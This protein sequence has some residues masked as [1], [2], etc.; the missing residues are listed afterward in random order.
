MT[1]KAI[2]TTRVDKQGYRLLRHVVPD[3]YEITIMPDL[4][5]FRFSGEETIF[6]R[7]LQPC[8]QIALN[9]KDLT[10]RS[11]CVEDEHGTRLEGSV[12]LDSETEMATIAFAGTLG[13][14]AWKLHL[15]FRGIHNDKLKGFYRA[16]WKDARGR[17]RWAAV[18]QFESTDARRAFPCFDEPEFKAV[19]SVKLVVDKN[20]TALSNGKVVKETLVAA[21]AGRRGNRKRTQVKK[22]VEFA[23][24]IKMSTYL[25]AFV[26]GDFVGSKPV[27]VDGI[28]TRVFTLPGKEHLTDFALEQACRATAFLNRETGMRF[29]G[30]HIYHVAIPN[31]ASGAMENWCLVTYRETALLCDLKTATHAEKKRVA[32]VV[33]HE[34]AHNIHFG[35]TVTMKWWNGLWLNESFATFQENWGVSVEY[36]QWNIWEEF[37]PSRA[38]A[39]RLDSLNTTHPIECVVNRPEDADELFD[40]ISYEKGCSIL[41]QIQ[42]FIGPEIFRQGVAAYIRKHAFGNTET[43]DLWDSLEEAC[44]A[45]GLNIPVRRIMDGWVF[46]PGHPVVT[47]TPAGDGFIDL[48]QQPFKF[49][50][51]GG[52]SQTWPVPVTVRVKKVNGEIETR[53]FLFEGK[54]HREFVGNYQWVVVNAGGSGFYR[55]RYE[56]SLLGKLTANVGENLSII[57]RFNLVNDTWSCVRAG[58]VSA[59]EYLEMLKLFAGETDPNV[60]SIITGSLVALNDLLPDAKKPALQ[61]LVRNLVAPAV[62]RLGWMAREGESVQ[63]SQ[64]R[65]MLIGVLGTIGGDTAVQAKADELFASYKADKSSV[66]SELLAAVVRIVSHTGDAA[67][68]EQFFQMFKNASASGTPQ[69]EQRFLNALANFQDLD[70]LRK[71]LEHTLNGQVR[72][73]DAPY[74]VATLINNSVASV[75]AWRFMKK[76]WARM[77]KTYPDNGVVRMASSVSALD[78][79]ELERE[80]KAFFDGRKVK[81]GQMA[82]AQA[83]EQLRVNVLL[84]E[85]ESARLASY[86]A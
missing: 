51:Q 31:F 42:Q 75:E 7:V 79:P 16:S 53:K 4:E 80:V 61:A 65:G 27:F 13:T 85:R 22:V 36:P 30:D 48:T 63:T 52:E 11:A 77:V 3:R 18:T 81:G 20:L 15:K 54:E 55:V 39:M 2:P 19:F 56:G 73:Q 78:T 84:R 25:V 37:G 82:V 28:E 68:Y 40:L 24:T 45:S 12:T 26:V 35:D 43:H 86:L 74:L 10:I 5:T 71:T 57:E 62:E 64:L 41:Y 49:L 76:N 33:W 69:E 34:L 47:V 6:V 67:D 9:A 32:E 66:D 59:P 46:T 29:P 14:G 21:P 58:L 23:D 1:T 44:K 83:L 38:A 72:S 17:T 60:W 70:L 8:T 50:P